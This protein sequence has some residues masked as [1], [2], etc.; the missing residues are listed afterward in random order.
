MPLEN[1]V[2]GSSL[3]HNI[4]EKPHLNEIQV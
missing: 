4:N 1:T 3:E 2:S